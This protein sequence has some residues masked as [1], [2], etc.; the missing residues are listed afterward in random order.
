MLVYVFTYVLLL[1]HVPLVVSRPVWLL[2]F[3]RLLPV[4]PSLAC[5]LLPSVLF[6]M[7]PLPTSRPADDVG[8]GDGVGDGHGDADDDNDALADF[9]HPCDARHPTLTMRTTIVIDCSPLHE[10]LI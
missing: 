1:Q 4:L 7:S 6:F 9:I 3:V 5:P 2:S 10:G 8:D